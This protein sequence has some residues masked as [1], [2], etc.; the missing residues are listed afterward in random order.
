MK[1]SYNNKHHWHTGHLFKLTLIEIAP[2]PPELPCSVCNRLTSWTEQRENWICFSIAPQSHESGLRL[3][4]HWHPKQENHWRA[5]AHTQHWES[6]PEKWFACDGKL[7]F[8]AGRGRLPEAN[9]SGE[10]DYCASVFSSTTKQWKS[11]LN[12]ISNKGSNMISMPLF[13]KK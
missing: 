9:R 7:F 6:T 1:I 2:W 5:V 3:M 13:F 4:F 12:P 8:R 10:R 11:I